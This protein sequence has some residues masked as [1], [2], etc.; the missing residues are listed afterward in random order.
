M[1]AEELISSH[2]GAKSC[3]SASDEKIAQIKA[4]LTEEGARMA[5]GTLKAAGYS[6]E[7]AI[8]VLEKYWDAEGDEAK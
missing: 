7:E 1:E 8:A 3:I 4:E 6:K 5:I 2:A